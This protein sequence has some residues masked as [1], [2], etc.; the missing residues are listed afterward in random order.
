MV[1][2]SRLL[3]I[4]LQSCTHLF[5]TK[6]HCNRWDLPP[7]K[8]GQVWKVFLGRQASF[9]RFLLPQTCSDEFMY[10]LAFG[11]GSEWFM[12]KISFGFLVRGRLLM[13]LGLQLI[14]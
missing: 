1:N 11:S 12:E 13:L 10:R 14:L 2:Q 3:K 6:T 9:I 4:K 5:R 8:L 7:R